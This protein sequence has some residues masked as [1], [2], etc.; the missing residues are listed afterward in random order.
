MRASAFAKTASAHD[1]LEKP[2]GTEKSALRG[3]AGAI[4]LK[5]GAPVVVGSVLQGV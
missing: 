4:I 2:P 5:K 3:P 1:L